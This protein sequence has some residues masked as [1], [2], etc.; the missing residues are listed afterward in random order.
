MKSN[1][2]LALNTSLPPTLPR[3]AEDITR[4][5]VVI[6]PSIT[7]C[8]L[9]LYRLHGLKKILGMKPLFFLYICVA[10]LCIVGPMSFGTVFLIYNLRFPFAVQCSPIDA[11]C[12]S[13]YVVGHMMLCFSIGVIAVAQ[14]MTVDVNWKRAV[15]IRKL[16]VTCIVLLVFVLCINV[17]FFGAVCGQGNIKQPSKAIT[18]WLLLMFVLPLMVITSFSLL[19]YVK[20]KKG[21]VEDDKKILRS[22]ALVSAFNVLQFTV[23]R[24]VGLVLYTMSYTIPSPENVATTGWYFRCTAR[25][26]TDLSYPLTVVTIFIV[27]SKLR[28]TL[29]CK[30]MIISNAETGIV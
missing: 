3:V 16:A 21:I 25:L 22:I 29:C 7:V 12:A 6:I 15:N 28:R 24:S 2:T 13:V 4:L 8:S 27:H 23:L 11:I 26:V 5:I 17:V 30:D 14:F 19:T 18:V 20:V 9:L 1:D 10:T